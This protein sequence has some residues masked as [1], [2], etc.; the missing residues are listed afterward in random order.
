MTTLDPMSVGFAGLDH[1]ESHHNCGSPEKEL[2]SAEVRNSFL[3]MND[4]PCP[5]VFF[6]VLSTLSSSAVLGFS[7]QTS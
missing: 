2:F 1:P 6:P 5:P 4:G 3:R 7:G